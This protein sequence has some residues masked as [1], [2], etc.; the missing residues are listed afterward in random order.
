MMERKFKIGQRVKLKKDARFPSEH[1]GL[2]EGTVFIINE[3][4]ERLS[5]DFWYKMEGY[6]GY[7]FREDDLH[8][9]CKL[10]RKNQKEVNR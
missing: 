10:N 3:S 2:P 8:L 9:A 1:Y 6:P 7:K 4:P 5:G